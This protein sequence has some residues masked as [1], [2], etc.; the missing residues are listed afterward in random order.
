MTFSEYIY[1]SFHRFWFQPF[2]CDY[3]NKPLTY[4]EVAYKIMQIHEMLKVIGIKHGDKIAICGKNSSNW[5][6]VYLSIVSYGAVVVPL[7]TD[8]NNEKIEFLLKH[9]ESKLFF[10]DD[11]VC[12]FLHPDNMNGLMAIYSLDS[13]KLILSAQMSEYAIDIDRYIVSSFS[14]YKFCN[15]IYRYG[16]EELVSINYTS[17]TSSNPK[18]VM[19]PSRAISSNLDFALEVMHMLHENVRTICL[20]PMSH[21]F[22]LMYGFLSAM[23]FGGTAHFLRC[24]L[25]SKNIS[26]IYRE[27]K[28]HFV[29]IVPIIIESIVKD[30]IFKYIKNRHIAP[31]YS[32][33]KSVLNKL[34]KKR[35][36]SVFGGNFYQIIIGGAYLDKDVERYLKELRIPFT[37]GYGMTECSPIISYID[38]KSF[39]LGSCG[40]VA[41]R[42]EIRIGDYNEIQVKGQNV[43]TGYYHNIKATKESFTKD[44]WLRTGDIGRIDKEGNLYVIGRL[45]TVI[46]GNDGKNIYPEDVEE[47]IN[48]CE[49]VKESL[50]FKDKKGRLSA[51]VYPNYDMLECYIIKGGSKESFLGEIKKTVNKNLP[52][53][54]E[55]VEIIEQK[56]EFLKTPKMTIKRHLYI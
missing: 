27:I 56:T 20:L 7:S 36:I 30:S 53:N 48:K 54:Q 23:V 33:F 10:V 31:I 52:P 2:L 51:Y 16:D 32:V 1:Y 38:H 41:P 13:L 47:I 15:S 44:G 21:M 24:P 40:K 22:G 49:L 34:I 42:M 17:G 45:N 50:V 12:Q 18:G 29:I 28:P 35:L 19:I 6:I 26:K 37:V 8:F 55:I 25:T 5:G 11:D 3:P 46:L 14:K 43:M 39:V 9:S 4:K